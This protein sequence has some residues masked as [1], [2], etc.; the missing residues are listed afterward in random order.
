MGEMDAARSLLEEAV[1]G[2]VAQLGASHPFTRF[3]T[4]RLAELDN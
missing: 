2:S 4:S 3:A 1:D